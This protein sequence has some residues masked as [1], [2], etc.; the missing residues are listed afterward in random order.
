MIGAVIR[1]IDTGGRKKPS[2]TTM[3]RIAS[4]QHPAR[5][6]HRDDRLGGRLADV[7]I[8]HHVG[9]EQRH[10]DDQHQHGRFADRRCQ[11]RREVARAARRCRSARSGSARAGRRGRRSPTAWRS[12]RRARPSRRSA[13][14]RTAARAAARE[15]FGHREC[16]RASRIAEFAPVCCRAALAAAYSLRKRNT[17]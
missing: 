7:Q 6:M 1:M 9:I 3:T 10:A 14:A 4:Q 8:A 11:D 15:A 2:T 12:R 16:R 5:Q 13:A 17:A